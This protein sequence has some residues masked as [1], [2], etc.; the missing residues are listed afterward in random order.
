MGRIAPEI[1]AAD[2]VL[3]AVGIDPF[4]QRLGG[5]PALRPVG[6]LDAGDIGGKP[7][8]IATA[9]AAAVVGP[10]A[11]RLQARR[12]RLTVVVAEG[13]GDAGLQAGV[14]GRLQHIKEFLLEA[15][16]HAADHVVHHRHAYAVRSLGILPGEIVVDELGE[17][18]CDSHELA[19][20]LDRYF[21][22]FGFLDG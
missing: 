4:P 15:L 14:L 2:P 22:P 20:A 19:L 10:V 8:A 13:A 12:D 3:L 11:C 6:T 17:A 9:R 16:V 5:N 21:A 18:S 7:A 1:G